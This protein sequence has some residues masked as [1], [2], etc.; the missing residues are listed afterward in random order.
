MIPVPSGQV[1]FFL[2]VDKLWTCSKE[3]ELFP[4]IHRAR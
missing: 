2:L 1:I 4:I 3:I